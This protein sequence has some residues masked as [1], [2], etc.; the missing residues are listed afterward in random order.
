[1]VSWVAAFLPESLFINPDEI[2]VPR[3]QFCLLQLEVQT[4]NWNNLLWG[5]YIEVNK[6]CL[7]D[8]HRLKVIEP[9]TSPRY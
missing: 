1:M 2:A 3:E 7:I 5:T 4:L 8:M 9:A 6:V